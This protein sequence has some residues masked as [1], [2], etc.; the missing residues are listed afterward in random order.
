VFQRRTNGAVNFYQTYAAYAAGF[1]TAA[2]EYW[3]GN[4]RLAALTAAGPTLRI[5][6]TRYTG[7]TGYAKYAG[8]KVA[9]AADAYRLS[10]TYSGGTIGDSLS[11]QNGMQFTTLDADHDAYASNCAVTFHGA[12]WYNSCHQS[13]LN[14]G[15][16]NGVHTSYADGMEWNTWTGQYESMV[17]TEMKVR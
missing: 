4:D 1:G 7:A 5:D 17:K 10:L 14:G 11:Y 13:N 3:M 9:T 2:T 12:W 15:Y 16:L 6:L 8:F